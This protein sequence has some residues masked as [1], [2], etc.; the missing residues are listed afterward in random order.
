VGEALALFGVYV[1]IGRVDAALH[2][3]GHRLDI[4]ID[5]ALPFSAA[6]VFAYTTYYLF[7]FSPLFY[8][9]RPPYFRRV[10][11]AMTATMAITYA[12]YLVLPTVNDLRPSSLDGAPGFAA[13]LTR[14]VY[15]GDTLY[16]GF[17]SLHIALS[18]VAALSLGEVDR[19]VRIG[20]WIVA[21][22][23]GISTVLLKQHYLADVAGGVLLGFASYWLTVGRYAR[24]HP[25]EDDDRRP[26]WVLGVLAGLQATG[27]LGA[28][29][30]YRTH[31]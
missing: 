31:G 24:R 1:V 30:W 5:H 22:L 13:W 23:I 12:F 11:A 9:R 2:V 15:S 14:L 6:W 16:N 17:P 25:P 8:A 7:A 28:F 29:V 10:F 4:P 20:A 18:C 21:A 27:L 19:R 3:T 26:R